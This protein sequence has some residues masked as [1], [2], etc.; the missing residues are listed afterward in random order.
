MDYVSWLLHLVLNCEPANFA[1]SQSALNHSFSEA[2]K[3]FDII[4][5]MDHH[6]RK[7]FF[8][9]LFALGNKFKNPDEIVQSLEKASKSG[10]PDASPLMANVKTFLDQKQ[11]IS[12]QSTEDGDDETDE[13]ENQDGEVQDEEVQDG[14]VQD[15]EKKK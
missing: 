9:L 8:G 14:E 2:S 15:E 10:Y 7:F 1:E 4:N 13:E 11:G 5:K 3:M 12:E 6:D